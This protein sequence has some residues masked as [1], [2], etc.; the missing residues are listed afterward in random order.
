MNRFDLFNCSL[1]PCMTQDNFGRN[2]HVNFC[3]M[4]RGINQPP[5]AQSQTKLTLTPFPPP[6]RWLPSRKCLHEE[7]MWELKEFP[8]GQPVHHDCVE[9]W[10]GGNKG[11]VNI[12]LYS[13]SPLRNIFPC[14]LLVFSVDSPHQL[15]WY[16]W[17]CN[18]MEGR[19]VDTTRSVPDFRSNLYQ[20]SNIFSLPLE[21][22]SNSRG[23]ERD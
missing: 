11:R 5:L 19:C 22:R 6:L 9:S 14:Q 15:I 10:H 23:R 1:S 18:T 17:V 8:Y 16:K 3:R 21:F 13:P 4:G 12:F 20:I 2:L 7:L